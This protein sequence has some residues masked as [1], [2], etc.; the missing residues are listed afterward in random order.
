ME[1]RI[2]FDM[3]KSKHIKMINEFELSHI[4]ICMGVHKERMIV[5]QGWSASVNDAVL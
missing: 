3:L 4:H 2:C 1:M 5:N